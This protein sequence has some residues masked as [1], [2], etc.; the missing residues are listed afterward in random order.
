MGTPL[1]YITLPKFLLHAAFLIGYV[2]RSIYRVLGIFKETVEVVWPDEDAMS[3][4]HFMAE[5]DQNQVLRLET[6]GVIQKELGDE[7]KNDDAICAVCL[8]EFAIDEKVLL[9]INC[10]H[11]YHEICLRKWLDVQQK[12][13]PLCRSPLTTAD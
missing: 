6:F 5:E 4:P 1:H 9:L 3:S 7:L 11:V 10:C 2:G 12:S 13:C 8:N